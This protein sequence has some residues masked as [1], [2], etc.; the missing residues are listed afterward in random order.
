[1]DNTLTIQQKI[2]RI[3]RLIAD[4]DYRQIRE[5]LEE[6][7]AADVAELLNEMDPEDRVIVFRLLHK[8]Q[9]ADVFSYLDPPQR[10]DIVE[11]IRQSQ[12]TAILEELSFDDLIDFLEEM[13]ANIVR[14]VIDTSDDQQR[15]LINQFLNYPEN[16]AGSLMTIEYVSLKKE[17]TVN[18]ALAH[19]RATGPD[20]ETI[21]TCY[22]L[23]NTRRLEGIISLRRLVLSEGHEAIGDLMHEDLLTVHTTE[24]QEEVAALFKKYDIITLP[25]VD[26]EE[27]L[28]GI[29]TIDDI[30]D[31]IEQEN[32]ED[33]Q[34]MA[35][36]RPTDENYL[37]TNPFVLARRRIPWLLVLMISA[38]FTGGIIGR[39]EALLSNVAILS[40]FIPMLMD[41]A[42]N[43]GCQSSTLII[44]GLATGDVEFRDFFRVFRKEV[45]VSMIV[46]GAMVIVNGVRLFIQ[47]M[48]VDIILSVSV[49]LMATIVLAKLTGCTLPMIA[50]KLRLDPAIMAA[51]LITTVVD[52]LSLIVFFKAASFFVQGLV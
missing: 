2:E 16:S 7:F 8:D 37:D 12:L 49:A 19:I 15:K 32:T 22:V 51:P 28:V 34:V 38:T 9:A 42:G 30:V 17:M 35:A 47:Q 45:A 10:M 44:R 36:M 25:V 50:K 4:R 39:Y 40:T 33:F 23:D 1:M 14:R 24:D 26:T 18:D 48:P 20:K 46:G 27:R 3:Q 41:S 11:A 5:E 6:D 31:V 29:I 52:A 13:P 21:Y 43:A